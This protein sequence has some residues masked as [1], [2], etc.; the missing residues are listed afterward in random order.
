MSRVAAVIPARLAS[1]RLPRKPLLCDTGKYL[2][3]HVWEQVRQARAIGRVLI[4]TDHEEILRAAQ[5]FGAEVLLTAAHHRCG[6][7]RVAEVAR[8]LELGPVVNVQ[9][10][11]PEIDPAA[12]DRLAELLAEGCP[13][14]TLAARIT[15]NALWRDRNAVKVVVSLDGHALYFSRAAIPEG[16]ESSAPGAARL[17]VGTYGYQRDVLARLTALPP[18]PLEKIERLE[19]LRAL[20]NGIRIRV[21]EVPHAFAGIDTPEDYRAFVARY[22]HQQAASCSTRSADRGGKDP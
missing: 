14:A 15:D 11:E 21:L 9:G 5:S 19:Q 20:E 2:V 3:Q 10:D 6:T 16:A 13:M 1:T 12:L 22:A 7:D 8:R 17:H 18:S 4:A